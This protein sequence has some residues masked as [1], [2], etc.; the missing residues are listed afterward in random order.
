MA[1]I[2]FDFRHYYQKG[3]RRASES[4][5]Y[6]WDLGH[7]AEIFVPVNATYE[8]H[9][10]FGG[11]PETD[12]YAVESI[13]AADDG[14]Y[15]L[16]A[17]IPNYLFERSGEL[18]IFIVG[19]A[20]NHILTTYEGYITIRNRIQPEDYVD[21]D[22][23]N[24]AESIIARAKRYADESEAWATGE[25]DGTP[26][27]STDPQYHNN[28]EYYAGLAGTSE[29]NA[30][31]SEAS[32]AADALR[33]EGYAVGKQN[34]T[35]VASDSPYYHNNSE[36]YKDQAAGSE[37]QAEAWAVGEIDGTPVPS[38]A[39]Q[40]QN[41]AEYYSDQAAASATSAAASA[42]QIAT[43]LGNFATVEATSTASQAYAVGKF[44]VLN[45]VLYRVTTAIASG[46]TITPGTNCTQTTVGDE[47]ANDTLFFKDK[48]V[49]ATTGD[50]LVINDERITADHVLTECV[51]G[52]SSYI[53]ADVTWTTAAG[54]LTL[55]GTATAATTATVTLVKKDN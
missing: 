51:W 42:A 1:T 19:S 28:A 52:N 45:G 55:N 15:K 17:H 20:D 9:Y 38:T 46:G 41:N 54:S 11:E 7:V 3:E 23:E 39:P 30:A 43:I 25:V 37:D 21:D 10:C 26:V 8:M 40:Y 44:L 32:A 33:A 16:T 13:A 18:R 24:G 53:T 35:A 36:Y 49:T 5:A 50:I 31:A 6:Q 34:G 47:I 22:P 27:E 4:M 29:T 2:T 12:D 48:A 14:G